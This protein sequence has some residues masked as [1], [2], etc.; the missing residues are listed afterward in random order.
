LGKSAG[1]YAADQAAAGCATVAAEPL[2]RWAKQE[3]LAWHETITADP[4]LPDRLLPAGYLGKKA[5]AER[6]RILALAHRLAPPA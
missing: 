4:L 3:K 1:N 2:S 6:T 5:W